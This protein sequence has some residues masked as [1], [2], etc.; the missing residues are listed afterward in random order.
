MCVGWHRKGLNL[1]CDV[2]AYHLIP[3]S[4]SQLLTRLPV[5]IHRQP[6]TDAGTLLH[7]SMASSF[8]QVSYSCPLPM[9]GKWDIGYIKRMCTAAHRGFDS[10]IGYYTACIAECV[11]S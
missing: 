9:S 4:Q 3:S 11:S 2:V 1:S 7:G 6:Q 10:F 5:W 8:H